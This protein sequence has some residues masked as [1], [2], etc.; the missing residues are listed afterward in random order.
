VAAEPSLKWVEVLEPVA[1]GRIRILPLTGEFGDL[2]RLLPVP[3]PSPGPSAGARLASVQD[4]GAG[5]APLPQVFAPRP[6]PLERKPGR[7]RTG[8]PV[9]RPGTGATDP[10]QG[11]RWARLHLEAFQ[12]TF[13]QAGVRGK[14]LDAAHFKVFLTLVT[15]MDNR[16][17]IYETQ[18]SV[19]DRVNL[20]P[21][22][23]SET[24]KD[25]EGLGCLRK[26]GGRSKSSFIFLNPHLLINASHARHREILAQWE[27]TDSGGTTGPPDPAESA[28][29]PEAPDREGGEVPF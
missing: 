9:A 27:G 20:K 14:V 21:S 8:P 12:T 1:S 26:V 18:M 10:W 28:W 4:Q 29:P 22:R 23:V 7:T 3:A 2:E 15:L 17:R 25:L 5:V 16:N 13:L 19:A 6:A 24:L 11:G